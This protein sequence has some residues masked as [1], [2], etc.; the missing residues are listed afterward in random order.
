MRGRLWR[1]AVAAV[2]LS[3][4]VA[5]CG[6]DT[7]EET[8]TTAGGGTET[9]AGGGDT[10]APPSGG[11]GGTVRI[12]WGGSPADLNPGN[13]V[14]SE[15][16]T[17]YEL[18]YD[19]PI[20]LDLDGNYI[21]ELATDWSVSDDE[22]TWTLTIRDDAV[23]HD[24]TPLTAEDVAFTLNLYQA[25]EDFP[26]LPSYLYAFTSI[27]APDPTTVVLTTEAPVGNFESQMVFMYILPKHIWEAEA[28][29]VAFTNDAMIGTGSFKLAEYRQ[30]EFVRLDANTEYW[31]GA[32]VV[33]A[34]VFQTFENPDARVQALINGDVDMITEFPATAIATLQG[35][36]EVTVVTGD[37]L[38]PSL[39]DIFFNVTEPENCP[40]DEGGVCSGHPALRDLAVRRAMAHGVDKQQ[41]I[42]VALLGLGRPG[43]GLVPSGLGDWYAEELESEDYAFDLAEGNRLLDEAGYLDSDGDGTRDCPA[44]ADSDCGPTG[45]LTFRVNY[46]TDSD[47]APRVTELVQGW[48]SELGIK[49]EIQGLDAD[50]LTSVCC[51]TFDY[52]IIFWGWGSDPDPG[53]LLSVLVTD[54]IP[55][56][57]SETGYS[58]PTYDELF[59]LQG[60]QTDRAERRATIVEL[61][62]IALE[63]VPYII[64]W[65]DQAVQAY[66]NDSFTG[67][68]DSASKVALEDPSSL[69]VIAPAG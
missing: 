46:P 57:F 48:W 52:D 2:V 49:T 61:Q 66:R 67:W 68:Q 1:F 22:L 63:D 26:F 31:G 16:Y 65:Y 6:G 23:F 19:T 53:F 5:A 25:T 37:P 17:L 38:A 36:S 62:R 54:E 24:G 44:D 9:T 18:V 56:G 10:T 55:T 7:T 3:M 39:N 69:N 43:L 42:D 45:D 32:P 28:D 30:G 59:D 12:G 50:T 33:D 29:P 58:N 35:N 41:L 40:T 60:T 8:T 15:D 27:E 64:P 14:L 20:G 13:G 51:P 47:T 21:P 34:A 4:V 11:E